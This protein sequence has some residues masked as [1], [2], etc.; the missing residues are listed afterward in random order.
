MAAG[1]DAV[2]SGLVVSLSQPGG[3]ITGSTFFGPEI[4]AKRLEMLKEAVPRLAR[5]AVLLNPNSTA[6]RATLEAMKKTATALNVELI[7][8]LSRSPE[9]FDD[10]FALA[11]RRRADGLVVIDDTIFVANM[12]RL[13]AL[14][15][16]RNLPGAGSAE[17]AEGGGLLVYGVNFPELWRRAPLF[18]DKI[19]KG[20]KPATIPVERASKFELILNLKTANVLG[21]TIPQS[22]VL[23]ADEVI[24]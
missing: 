2:A 20:G 1:A 22:L 3:N 11:L 18:V 13:G 17:Y 5:V 24:R 19:L 21:L 4:S 10:A 7:E 15:V 9:D 23:R 8:V 16:A 12:R 6:P 14:S